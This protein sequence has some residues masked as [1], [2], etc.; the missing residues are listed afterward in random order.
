MSTQTTILLQVTADKLGVTIQD[1]LAGR[2]Q[3]QVSLARHIVAYFLSTVEKK[4]NEDVALALGGIDQSAIFYAVK[5]T[6]ERLEK[7]QYVRK[8][9]KEISR[10]V[11]G[12]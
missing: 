9:V 3:A 4:K 8:M 5:K 1:I 2:R 6:R 7:S 10:D 11:Y 12:E